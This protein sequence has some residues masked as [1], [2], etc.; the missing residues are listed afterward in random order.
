MT[1][2]RVNSTGNSLVGNQFNSS[3]MLYGGVFCQN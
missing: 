3:Y 2:L 1:V